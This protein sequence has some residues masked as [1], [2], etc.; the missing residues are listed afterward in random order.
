MLHCLVFKEQLCL[1]GF[2]ESF[3]FLS[4]KTLIIISQLIQLVKRF[5]KF[6]FCLN[7]KLFAFRCLPVKACSSFVLR[8]SRGDLYYVTRFPHACQHVFRKKFKNMKTGSRGINGCPFSLGKNHLSLLE[9]NGGSG[10]HFT[11]RGSPWGYRL[12]HR[13]LQCSRII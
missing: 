7:S 3:V 13:H 1:S 8:V 6:L 9:R 2:S 4:L 11:C 10:I 5:F 12:S